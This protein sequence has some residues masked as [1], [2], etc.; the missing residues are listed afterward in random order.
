MANP[1]STLPR[2]DEDQDKKY[3]PYD[4]GRELYREESK[5]QLTAGEL[6]AQDQLDAAERDAN[7][8]ISPLNG[9]LYSASPGGKRAP[10]KRG[11]K[12]PIAAL[13]SSLLVAAGLGLAGFGQTSM[14]VSLM[15]NAGLQNDSS[16]IVAGARFFDVFRSASSSGELS[17]SAL[18][19]LARQ[20][21]V[22]YNGDSRV[23][24]SNGRYPSA[25]ITHYDFTLRDGTT[26][27]VPLADIETFLKDKPDLSSK[28]IGR[29]GA[30]NLRVSMWSSKHL[31]STLYKRLGIKLAGGLADGKNGGGTVA[32]RVANL[33][34]KLRENMPSSEKIN[35]VADGVGGKVDRQLGKAK[36]GGTG[37]MM[38]VAGCIG[39]KAPGYI[40]AGVAAVQ[41][42]QV[43]PVIVDTILSPGSMQMASGVDPAASTLNPDDIEAINATL[44]TRTPRESDGK[45]TSALDSQ[46]L[47]SALGINEGKPPVSESLTPGLA[48]LRLVQPA[49]EAEQASE[50][51]CNVIL[52]PSAMYTAAAVDAAVTVAASATIIGGIVKVI[53]SFAIS[54][55][56]GPIASAI[57]S[58]SAKSILTEAAK[59]EAIP[60][61]EGEAFGDLLGISMLSFFPAA[62]MANGVPTLQTGQLSEYNEIRS[63]VIENERNMDIATL[64]PF[65]TS[66][67]HTFMGSIAH[68]FGTLSYSRSS[69]G[70]FQILGTLLRLPLFQLSD[71][72]NALNYSTACGYAADFGLENT[73]E[74]E[75]SAAINAAG[76]PCGGMTADQA[77]MSRDEAKRLMVEQGWIDSS[78]TID[79]DSTITEMVNV[80]YI[81][82]DN[83]LYDYIEGCTD[84]TTG[85]YLFSSP[86]CATDS[87]SKNPA[88]VAGKLQG[89]PEVCGVSGGGDSFCP[90]NDP[91][92]SA[93]GQ[94]PS[95]RALSAIPVFIFNTVLLGVIN[96]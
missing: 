93:S 74:P 4:A 28:L 39:V 26:Q 21:I 64:S 3:S 86:G 30:F 42:A 15:Q 19:K 32:E 85:D 94:V 2:P 60:N 49:V 61:A 81:K 84:A 44:T 70:P 5:P 33:K 83:P 57:V 72:A 55:A 68:S 20:G 12:G 17:N 78:I 88:D 51:A 41:L 53:G 73:T 18:K 24:T 50:E 6:A 90:A 66:S 95:G 89:N 52:S 8:G 58:E 11:R 47:Q 77:A 56:A 34:N 87:E 23:D 65:D 22:A 48:V 63:A 16:S 31:T 59:S 71:D 36:A 25:R 75:K 69:D 46:I 82:K 76:L 80:G 91:A 7:N 13:I 37:Y 62:N 9:G 27:R 14:L 96:E 1:T 38:S 29:G 54:E 92:V 45:L 43:A 10:S 67:P 79:K 40:A 35:S